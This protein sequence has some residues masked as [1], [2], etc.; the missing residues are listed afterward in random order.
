MLLSDLSGLN[1]TGIA[2][3]KFHVVALSRHNDA[4]TSVMIPAEAFST[5]PTNTRLAVRV[6]IIVN[7]LSETEV[8]SRL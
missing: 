2:V 1:V 8:P 6:T 7:A 3:R 5:L 4:K